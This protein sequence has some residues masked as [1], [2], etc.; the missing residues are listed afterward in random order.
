MP[1]GLT[2]RRGFQPRLP[3]SSAATLL[4]NAIMPHRQARFEIASAGF[5]CGHPIKNSI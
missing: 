2:G 5:V 3:G 1:S 4:S